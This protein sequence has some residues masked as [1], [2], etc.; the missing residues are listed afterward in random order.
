MPDR[1]NLSDFG[2]D[3]AFVTWRLKKF[4]YCFWS[5]RFWQYFTL[6]AFGCYG[7][8]LVTY[9]FKPFGESSSSH[10]PIDD[11]LLTWA[12]SIGAIV[13][14]S[15]RVVFGKLID[16]LSFRL[17][18]SIVLT[19]ELAMCL[20]FYFAANSPWFFFVLILLNYA[21]L[22]GFFTI[23][24][25]SVTRIYG[26]ELGPQVYVQI[27]MGSFLSSLFNLATTKWLL[28]ATGYLTLF[29]GGSLVTVVA[30]AVLCFIKEDLDV[31]NLHKKKALV[32]EPQASPKIK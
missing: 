7:S 23:L 27:S 25:V 9:A 17:L 3:D 11:G 28:P 12:A 19:I 29:A 18:M 21:I 14:G 8:T 22:G 24:P 4:Y 2:N 31:E 16:K 6:M 15:M 13:N 26:L 30:L 20:V 5:T 10:S 1:S 32:S